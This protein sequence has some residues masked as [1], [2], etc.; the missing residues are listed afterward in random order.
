[1][2]G[3]GSNMQALI[4]AAR[5]PSYPADIALVLSNRPEAAGLELARAAGIASLA[6]D[7]KRYPERADFDAE[8]DRSLKSHGIEFVACA[9]YMRIMTAEFVAGWEG[10]MVNIHPSLLPL[11]RGV[12][13]HER[14]L[15]DGL[16][17]H[18]CTVHFVTRELDAG[19]IIAQA[20]VPV[21]P[22]DT[23]NALAARVLRAEHRLYPMALALVASGKARIEA[24]RANIDA[25]AD[26]TAQLFSPEPW[27]D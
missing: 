5:D 10:A 25:A 26:G 27:G 18:G 11:Y 2:S 3:R 15:A 20:A 8:L 16:R 9:G 21:L 6:I 7:H 13:T 22:G 24:G 14:A 4:A 17:I 1:M 19:P 23:A 12:R